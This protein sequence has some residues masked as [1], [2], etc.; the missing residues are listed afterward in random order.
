MIAAMV[1]FFL[2]PCPVL[3]ERRAREFWSQNSLI[4]LARGE[5]GRRLWANQRGAPAAEGKIAALSI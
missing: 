1:K 4:F 5:F 2:V 3:C